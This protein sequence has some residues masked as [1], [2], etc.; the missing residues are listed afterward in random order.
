MFYGLQEKVDKQI[1]SGNLD[2]PE[3]GMDA[4]MQVAACEKVIILFCTFLDYLTCFLCYD[5]RLSSF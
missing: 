5:F 4:L 3:G 1:I 2:E